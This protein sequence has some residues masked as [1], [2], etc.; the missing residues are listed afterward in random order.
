MGVPCILRPMVEPCLA[1]MLPDM[2]TLEGSHLSPAQ[3]Q[4]YRVVHLQQLLQAGSPITMGKN[5]SPSTTMAS[6]RSYVRSWFADG[7]QGEM[8]TRQDKTMRRL[9]PPAK[10]FRRHPPKNF[11][12]YPLKKIEALCSKK[13]LKMLKNLFFFRKKYFFRI[14]KIFVNKSGEFLK[15]VGVGGSFQKSVH[16]PANL[17]LSSCMWAVISKYGKT[18]KLAKI[19]NIW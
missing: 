7:G 14:L 3:L 8:K 1:R 10:N 5:C 2:T 4:C 17:T 9:H 19:F 11:R 15:I 18:S 12:G 13:L 16:P 6:V